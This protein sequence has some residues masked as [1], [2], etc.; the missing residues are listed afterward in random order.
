MHHIA[1]FI[2]EAC[3]GRSFETIREVVRKLQQHIFYEMK[4]SNHLQRK[5][6]VKT[7]AK[8]E[9]IMHALETN[10]IHDFS[11]ALFRA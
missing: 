6:K 3:I 9:Q 2:F 7:H 4:L 5:K 1:N 11:R 10:R 8:T